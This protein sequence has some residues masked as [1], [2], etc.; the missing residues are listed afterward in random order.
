MT[1]HFF[2]TQSFQCWENWMADWFK[3][4]LKIHAY[5]THFGTIKI[6]KVHTPSTLISLI[7]VYT[8]SNGGKIPNTLVFN[9]FSLFPNYS[10]FTM[11]SHFT[12]S[13]RAFF[14]VCSALFSCLNWILP[15]S[16]W[17]SISGTWPNHTPLVCV[18]IYAA[19]SLSLLKCVFIGINY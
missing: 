7:L 12:F 2:F 1:V 10:F 14:L 16:P 13:H 5:L 4:L 8:S 11:I 19:A 18:N 17:E 15:R 9:F 3:M 6:K